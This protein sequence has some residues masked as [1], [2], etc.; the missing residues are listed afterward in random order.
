MYMPKCD[1]LMVSYVYFYTSPQIDTKGL[2][3]EKKFKY[4]IDDDPRM[5]P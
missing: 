5:L 2:D 3:Q 4:E 1:S